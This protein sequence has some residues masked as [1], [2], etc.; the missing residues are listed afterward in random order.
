MPG[1]SSQRSTF[2]VSSANA[3]GVIP[4]DAHAGDY[5]E[6]LRAS[7]ETVTAGLGPTPA[8]AA[9]E[10]EKVLRWLEAPGVRLVRVDGEWSCPVR[11]AAKHLAT[12]D[13]VEQSRLTM[14]PFDERRSLPTVHQPAR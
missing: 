4:L 11:G 8:A 10:T 2:S 13:A 12:H 9:E 1:L 3:A 6:Q 7:A 5:V 14:V